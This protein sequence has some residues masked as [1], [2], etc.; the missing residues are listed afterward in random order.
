MIDVAL[1]K[2]P[3]TGIFNYQK[4]RVLWF[5]KEN[6]AALASVEESLRI[7]SENVAAHFLLQSDLF[8]GFGFFQSRKSFESCD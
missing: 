2:A 6:L 5:M 8:K 1:A 7:D 4:G 3:A